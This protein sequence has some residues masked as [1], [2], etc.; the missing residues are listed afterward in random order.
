M[1]GR[2]MDKRRLSTMA[3]NEEKNRKSL[4]LKAILGYYI[5]NE[6]EKKKYYFSAFSF[7]HNN[8]LI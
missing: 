5:E 1:Y 8:F 7:L 3:S 2:C 6:N 4:G